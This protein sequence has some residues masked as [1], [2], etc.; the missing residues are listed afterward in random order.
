MK[1]IPRL[2]GKACV[3]IQQ[4]NQE[5][6][7]S[8]FLCR[9]FP[10]RLLAR[11]QDKSRK[12]G[13]KKFLFLYFCLHLFAKVFCPPDFRALV[14]GGRIGPRRFFSQIQASLTGHCHGATSERL[15]ASLSDKVDAMR[16]CK[17]LTPF[18]LFHLSAPHFSYKRTLF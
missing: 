10:C 16:Q 14:A 11:K 1:A 13:V 4:I 7:F 18:C 8:P 2:D 9:T 3:G 12:N 6:V 17:E 15:L 5:I